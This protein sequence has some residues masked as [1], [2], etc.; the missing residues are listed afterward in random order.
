MDNKLLSDIM[1]DRDRVK[2][3]RDLMTLGILAD[4]GIHQ[5]FG[6]RVQ[7]TVSW[8]DGPPAGFVDA[9]AVRQWAREQLAELRRTNG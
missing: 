1:A 7:I 5:V 2:R 8:P 6:T 4:E 9:E 3:E